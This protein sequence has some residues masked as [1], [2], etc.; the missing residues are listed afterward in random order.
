[1][2]LD[3]PFWSLGLFSFLHDASVTMKPLLLDIYQEFYLPLGTDL[4]PCLKGLIL[5]ILPGLEEENDIFEHVFSLLTSLCQ[6]VGDV[7]FYYCLWIG[8]IKSP[9]NRL[10][11]FV[12][13]L[14]NFGNSFQVED[15]GVLIGHES[16][17]FLRALSVSLCDSSVLVQRNALDFLVKYLPFSSVQIF[18][19]SGMLL[20][21]S[22]LKTIL[23]RDMSLNRRLYSWLLGISVL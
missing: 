6:S 12:F 9:R 10:S 16:L 17:L 20:V 22:A 3:L 19:G 21:F 14:K 11:A 7:Y 5:A 18:N 2:V 13:L 15:L 1:M 23:R 8:I 4:K